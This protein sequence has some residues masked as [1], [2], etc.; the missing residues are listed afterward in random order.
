MAPL[1]PLTAPPSPGPWRVY[2]AARRDGR[3]F[4]HDSTGGSLA[5]FFDKPNRSDFPT[6]ENAELAA[7]APELRDILAEVLNATDF[8]QSE[9][10]VA[11]GFALLALLGVDC[12]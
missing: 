10:A 1:R 12:D 6:L 8:E 4:I 2:F 3:V 7:A 5:M 9:A 11:K